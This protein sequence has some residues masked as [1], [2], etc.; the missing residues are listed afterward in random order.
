[1]MKVI[2]NNF[3]NFLYKTIGSIENKSQKNKKIFISKKEKIHDLR[4]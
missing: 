2:K 3:M 4:Y 1:M